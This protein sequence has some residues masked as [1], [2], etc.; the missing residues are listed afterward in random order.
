MA[1]DA[2]V[3]MIDVGKG[4]LQEGMAA[5]IE[6]TNN[7]KVILQTSGYH[8]IDISVTISV[9]P[10]AKL[11]IE[12]TGSGKEKLTELM[13]SEGPTLSKVQTTMIR[14]MLKTYELADITEEY[15]YKFG[16]FN[17]TITIPPQVTVH[18]NPE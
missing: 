13:A 12:D 5:V 15:G 1:K 8:I 4:K 6:E 16:R 3:D 11:L 2:A 14:A 17:L 9:P 18:L 7:I 10:R